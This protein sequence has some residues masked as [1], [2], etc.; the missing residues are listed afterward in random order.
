MV[1][2]I[3]EQS[4]KLMCLPEKDPVLNRKTS[5]VADPE[6]IHGQWPLCYRQGERKS[7]KKKKRQRN[8]R[9]GNRCK[10]LVVSLSSL[11][12]R[13]LQCSS[14]GLE[15]P[16]TIIYQSSYEEGKP[17]LPSVSCH[18]SFHSLNHCPIAGHPSESEWQM[19]ERWELGCR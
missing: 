11:R 2:T 14:D 10:D 16:L 1:T 13:L 7:K 9:L 19:N 18:L 8:S 4:I 12:K 15:A 5:V 3:F 17:F 6:H